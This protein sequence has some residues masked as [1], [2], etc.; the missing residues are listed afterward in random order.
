[1][2][3]FTR[4]FDNALD[5][6]QSILMSILVKIGP[7]FVALCPASF[8]A[9]AIYK[10][11]ATEAGHALAL[12]FAL[13]VGIAWEAVGI[14][15]T[16]TATD[17]YN[18]WQDGKTQP[19]KFWV[20][21]FLIPVYV[22]GVAAVVGFSQDAFT[23]LVKGLGVASPF[24]T[25]VVYIAVALARDIHQTYAK[26][27]SVEDKQAALE[28]DQR[29]W[30]RERERL[31]LEHKHSEKLARIEAKNS[32]KNGRMTTK[33]ETQ[34]NAG[35][36]QNGHFAPPIRVPKSEWRE[37]AIGILRE[38][39]HIS[40]AE[41]GRKLGASERTGQN[42]LGELEQAGVVHK[43]GNGWEVVG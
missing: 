30:E 13:V 17:L 26:Q 25:V 9:Y 21:V 37:Q 28:A 23:P 12:F 6:I 41:L 34:E 16:H 3:A 32:A 24:L 29:E 20:M 8:T 33:Q 40:G 19:V 43:N 15:S 11:F 10:T 2:N 42:I 7:F 38:H 22:L 39:P 5:A 27:E 31:E 35:I 36:A 1:M 18:A 4:T 14:I